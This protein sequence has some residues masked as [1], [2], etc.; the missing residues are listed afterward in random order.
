MMNS[1]IFFF[2]GLVLNKNKDNKECQ[3]KPILD[4]HLSYYR[5]NTDKGFIKEVEEVVKA[6]VICFEYSSD[7]DN[8]LTIDFKI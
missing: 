1:L 3:E 5:I 6:N 7:G 2:E 8:S 4:L